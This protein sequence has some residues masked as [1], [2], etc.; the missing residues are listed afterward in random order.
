MPEIDNDFLEALVADPQAEKPYNLRH[1]ELARIRSSSDPVQG[2]LSTSLLWNYDKRESYQ[3][4]DG[5]EVQGRTATF[6]T[7]SGPERISDPLG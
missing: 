1:R 6:D 2:S 3:V 7:L 4:S 5:S